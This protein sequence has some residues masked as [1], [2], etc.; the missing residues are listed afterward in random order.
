MF[1]LSGKVLMSVLDLS[2]VLL[3]F[4]SRTPPKGFTRTDKCGMKEEVTGAR[5]LLSL[6]PSPHTGTGSHYADPILVGF[7]TQHP[8]K[9]ASRDFTPFCIY[10]FALQHDQQTLR[11]LILALVF[12]SCPL[13]CLACRVPHAELGDLGSV[14]P[15]QHYQTGVVYQIQVVAVAEKRFFPIAVHAPY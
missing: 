3:V 14:V 5:I 12:P 8:F 9:R 4:L 1:T 13:Y 6:S 15:A 2:Y 7:L 11:L 10:D